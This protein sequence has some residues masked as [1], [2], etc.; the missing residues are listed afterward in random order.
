MQEFKKF[1]V[2]QDKVFESDFDKM[3]KRML[4]KKK[5]EKI[6]EKKGN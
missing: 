5:A 2:T 6:V 3:A 1:R 4:K